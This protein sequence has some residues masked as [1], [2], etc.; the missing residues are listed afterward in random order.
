[1][2]GI[3]R[4][5]ATPRL[6]AIMVAALS[7]SAMAEVAGKVSF[8]Y[9]QV[10]AVSPD[11]VQRLL[12]RNGEVNSG[13]RLETGKGRLQIRFTDGSFLSLQP[14][15]VFRLDNY[16]FDRN[17]PDEG[18]LLFNFVQGGMRTVT[19]AIGRVN[20][21][22]YKVRTPVASLG[23]RGTGYAGSFR[24]GTLTLSVD[25]GI[26]HV[27]NEFGASN[28]NAGQTFQVVQGEAPRLAPGGVSA[29]ARALPPVDNV[30]APMAATSPGDTLPPE[31]A[32]LIAGENPDLSEVVL[33]NAL[34]DSVYPPGSGTPQPGYTLAT[35]FTQTDG[36]LLLDDLGAVFDRTSM[37]GRRGG[38]TGLTETRGDSIA[39]LFNAGSGEGALQFQ[40]VTTLR[41]LS[42]GEW[43]A[44]TAANGSLDRS[45]GVIALAAGRYE[46]YIIGAAAPQAL[47]MDAAGGS[48]QLSYRLAGATVADGGNGESGILRTLSLNI[49]LAPVT[50]VDV[51]L[52]VDMA[53][54]GQ[55]TASARNLLINTF[56]RDSL[57]GFRLGGRDLLASGQG[58]SNGCAVRL[59]AFF[60]GEDPQL[61][62]IYIIDRPG[63]QISGVAALDN[64]S[65]TTS[66]LLLADSAAPAYR[67]VFAKHGNL[68]VE[69]AI[70]ADFG[71]DGQ[72]LGGDTPNTQQY[73]PDS[74]ASTP[75]TGQGV[76]H[77]NKTLS[78]GQWVN[79]TALYGG[80]NPL[81]LN[82]QGVHYLVGS[83]TT[84][85][86]LPTGTLSYTL[87]G[88]S[89]PTL[90]EADGTPAAGSGILTS[91]SVTLDFDRQQAAM[92]LGMAFAAGSA[93]ASVQL[94]GQQ[95]LLSGGNLS[96]D[97]LAV[98]V[99]SN[100]GSAVACGNCYGRADGFVT[101][102]NGDMVG[103]GYAVSGVNVL[104]TVNG[105]ISGVAAYGNP[106][107]P[108]P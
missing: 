94:N 37:N 2:F 72:W 78:W 44:G 67:A 83:P 62:S 91:G 69:N 23:I 81:D 36:S 56:N 21:A 68:A 40:G 79:G 61:G 32:P 80:S 99:A 45:D 86:N 46:P 82:S 19:G 52:S 38:L 50:L 97:G 64:S 3:T 27:E 92:T 89:R 54:T 65:R 11:G 47:A 60:A 63:G 48:A 74:G 29:E 12:T 55:Y 101:G 33:A 70:S 9:G 66:S 4:L 25:K 28:V 57:S 51:D 43:T 13:E 75:A 87:V 16:R 20:R 7:G 15:T 26:V 106:Q 100:G 84:S 39:V 49:T 1:M 105:S 95:G 42:F 58:C 102:N 35:R 76:V 31:E 108:A 6:L 88:G 18:S 98:S 41:A 103:L 5:P 8:V 22:R 93:T 59:E 24:D 96:F 53:V 10:M 30:G 71:A 77:V 104:Q 17:R 90:A 107:T 85:G 34:P 14:N 73:G